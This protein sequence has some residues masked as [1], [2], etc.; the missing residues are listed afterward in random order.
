M[1]QTPKSRIE[2]TIDETG[3]V[4]IKTILKDLKQKI[5]TIFKKNK[6]N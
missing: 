5:K 6:T 1:K 2:K 4:V 3:V